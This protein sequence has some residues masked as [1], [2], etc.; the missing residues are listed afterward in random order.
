MACKVCKE[1]EDLE[2]TINSSDTQEELLKK[3]SKL[4]K[5][6]V[7]RFTEG[8]SL[9]CNNCSYSNLL[10]KDK[11]SDLFDVCME[12]MG[13]STRL[14]IVKMTDKKTA[15]RT[16][17]LLILVC[18]IAVLLSRDFFFSPT[19]LDIIH[20][21]VLL[22]IIPLHELSHF[23]TSKILGYSPKLHLLFNSYTEPFKKWDG[24]AVAT[25]PIFALTV[26]YLICMTISPQYSGALLLAIALNIFG[27]SQDIRQA[28]AIYKCPEGSYVF[29]NFDTEI[30]A[31]QKDM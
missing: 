16:E 29:G 24:I 23:I 6:E 28:I 31:Y 27:A 13:F 7:N 9:I 17:G 10:F 11:D 26:I 3:I 4:E 15:K 1:E 21:L 20:L 14:K 19:S 22:S 18:L 12:D 30:R 8:S 5:F 25:A 2:V